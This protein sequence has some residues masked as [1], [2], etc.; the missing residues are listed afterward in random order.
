MAENKKGFIL[1]CDLI[2][3]V[4]ELPDEIAGKLFKHVLSYV[5]DENP[6]TTDLLLKIAFEPIKQQLKR[7]LKGWE[8]TLNKKSDGGKKGM[9]SRWGKKDNIVIKPIT[10]DN[11]VIKP[12]TPITDTVTVTDTV[13]D[14]VTVK[15]ITKE[16][17]LIEIYFNDLENST[18]FEAIARLH[19]ITLDQL[20]K[21]VPDFKLKAELEYPTFARFVSHFK[22]YVLQEKKKKNDTKNKPVN[23]A[24]GGF[25]NL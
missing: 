24:K 12:I 25:G 19:Q 2:H 18:Q 5:N 4:S 8:K 10:S 13:K 15:D 22:N 6:Q 3:T 17:N 16:K 20:K 7:D 9:E 11:I 14:K 23:P 21:Y 1:Y